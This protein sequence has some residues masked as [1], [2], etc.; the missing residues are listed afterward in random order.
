MK[1]PLL[2]VCL[3]AAEAAVAAEAEFPLLSVLAPDSGVPPDGPWQIELLAL[4]PGTTTIY[5]HPPAELAAR[6]GA[7]PS[8]ADVVFRPRTQTQLTLPPGGFAS[9]SYVAVQPPAASGLVVLEFS[10]GLPGPLRT[11]LEVGTTPLPVASAPP[12]R[13]LTH[14]TTAVSALERTFAGRLGLHESIYFIYGPDAPAAKFQFSFKYRM[15]NLGR[16]SAGSFRHTLQGA[17][18]QRSL[19]DINASSSPFYDTSYMPELILESLAPL[20]GDRERWFALLGSQLAYK[21]ES[22][23]RDGPDSRSLDTVNARTALVLG[24]LDS[25][26]V[27]VAP[28][29][30]V[31]I[32]SLH[33]NAD[34]KD[35]RGY[36]QWRIGVEKNNR[37]PA[38]L[39][40]G[41]M[42][43]RCNHPTHQFDLTVPFRTRW[44]DIET[45]LLLQYFH[46]YG[47]S[48]L[49]YDEK[50][51]AWRAGFSLVR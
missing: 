30:F 2:L 6:L 25:W 45:A 46:G 5:Y 38:L 3:L 36:G 24:P 35:Y 41:R 1:W 49:S 7:D 16:D 33:E 32:R 28:E 44:F 4:N 27:L 31:Y 17:Y 47:E 50:S 23:G 18:T 20:P 9:R 8:A 13:H 43:R 10:A 34:L 40:T 22:N 12:L 48:L 51:E 39:Y 11:V 21:H 26:H 19:W 14:M 37:R 42:G 15:M 29:I